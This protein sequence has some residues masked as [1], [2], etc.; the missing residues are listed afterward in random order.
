MSSEPAPNLIAIHLLFSSILA[1]IKYL[2]NT[3]A[4][5]LEQLPFPLIS[6]LLL[7]C[8]ITSVQKYLITWNCKHNIYITYL[9]I[10]PRPVAAGTQP[11]LLT[12]TAQNMALGKAYIDIDSFLLS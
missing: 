4:N 5:I 12:P 8:S 9:F 10:Q 6:A 2:I 11:Q 7:Q 1:S 3:T